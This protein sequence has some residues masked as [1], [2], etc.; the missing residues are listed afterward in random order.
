MTKGENS[1]LT[2]LIVEDGDEYLQSLSQFVQG[3][4]YL[5]AHNGSQALQTL[6]KQH[7]DL[8]YLDMRF[9]RID[10]GDLLGDHQEVC[11][12]NNGD[13]AKAWRHL[14]NNQGLYILSALKE[15]GHAERPI[16][17]AYDFTNE[18]RRWQ[19]LRKNYPRLFWVADAVSPEEI[20][21]LIQKAHS[22]A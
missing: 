17:L 12:E 7:V 5:Q 6:Q 4:L 21:A 15:A 19:F 8:I 1:C 20:Q 11:L 9:D 18:E 16:V 14:Q 2:I 13:T 10:R 22:S 3:H